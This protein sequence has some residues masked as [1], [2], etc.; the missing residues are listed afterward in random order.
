MWK[1][2][3][4]QGQLNLQEVL[5]WGIRYMVA[6]DQGKAIA[7]Q[8]AQ[9]A[10]RDTEPLDRVKEESKTKDCKRCGRTHQ[11]GYCPAVGNECH[12]CGK[13]SHFASVCWSKG[14]GAGRGQGRGRGK[15]RGG[16]RRSNTRGGDANRDNGAEKKKKKKKKVIWVE[17]NGK[18]VPK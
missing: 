16:R 4:M 1:K 9:E 15:A 11:R 14:S 5:E 3:I 10:A 13:A 17:V 2:K 6:E 18:R 12:T 7:G 8:G